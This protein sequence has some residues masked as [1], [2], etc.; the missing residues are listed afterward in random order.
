MKTTRNEYDI[1]TYTNGSTYL[2]IVVE[3]PSWEIW[4]R[5]S[6]LS[7]NCTEVTLYDGDNEVDIKGDVLRNGATFRTLEDLQNLREEMEDWKPA[8]PDYEAII[9]S[10]NEAMAYDGPLA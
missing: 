7:R 5:I 1:V 9:E 2:E 6:M 3:K 10:R 8:E 4:A